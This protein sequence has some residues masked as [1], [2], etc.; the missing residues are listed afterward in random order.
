MKPISL[1]PIG[2]DTS[3]TAFPLTC[4]DLPTRRA[5]HPL[6]VHRIPWQSTECPANL[7]RGRLGRLCISVERT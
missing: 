7:P 4:K 2:P 3:R 5:G 6:Q 1:P